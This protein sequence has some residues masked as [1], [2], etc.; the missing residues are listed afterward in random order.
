MNRGTMNPGA[1]TAEPRSQSVLAAQREHIFPCVK[2]LYEEPLVLDRGTGVR[3]HDVDGNEYLDLFS[4]IL[5]TSVG[6][7]NPEVTRAVTAQATRLGHTSTLYVTEP[8]IE[9]A[10]RL[11][12]MAPGRLDRTFFTNS[13][14]EAIET[15]LA[16]ACLHTGRM[17]VVALRMAYHGRS[18]LANNVTAHAA[19]RPLATTN[20]GI[21]HAL[22][23]DTYRTPL[24]FE[25]EEEWS[26]YFARDLDEVIRTTTNGRPAAFIAETIQ[27]V[28]GYVVP[29]ASYFRKAAE[30]IRGYGGLLIIDEVQAGFGRTGDHWFGIEHWGVEPDIMVMAKGIAN[31]YPAAA[32]MTR[33]EIAKTWS[34]KTISTFGGNPISMAAC[35]AT[36]DV[37]EREDV[38]SRAAERGRQ[39]RS[40]LEELQRRYDWIGDVR[41][42]GL[43]QALDLVSDPVTKSADPGRA[44]AVLEAAKQERLL[45]GVGGH[46]GQVIRIGPSLLITQGDLEDGLERLGR[47]CARAD[48]AA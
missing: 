46:W 18:A 12:S 10:R 3:V 13:G 4:G 8:Q 43:M 24:P 31:G 5:S 30:I 26:E 35:V 41:G 1:A 40:G 38:R 34:G 42:L 21:K 20:V 22:S 39:L 33:E 44:K 32:T 11:T 25:T 29:P 16:M 15:A 7:C 45:I 27:G 14:T 47:A 9:A 37:M 48:R 2:P 19:W 23:P 6:H 17:E 28:A 36:L